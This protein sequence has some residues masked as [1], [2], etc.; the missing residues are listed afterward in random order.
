MAIL[1]SM[2]R[3]NCDFLLIFSMT[4]DVGI[5]QR[6]RIFRIRFLLWAKL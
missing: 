3:W 2:L 6:E 5:G 4:K 1:K